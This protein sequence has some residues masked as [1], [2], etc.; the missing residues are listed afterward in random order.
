MVMCRSTK[1]ALAVASGIFLVLFTLVTRE[2]YVIGS[3]KEVL[4]SVVGLQQIAS[5]SQP[6]VRRYAGVRLESGFTVQAR[7]DRHITLVPGDRA[8]FL[9]ITTP[10]FGFKRYRFLR[11]LE[12]NRSRSGAPDGRVSQ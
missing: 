5:N 7:V 10:M 8:V 1:V 12:P 9:E 2:I 11:H 4:G 3:T 6:L